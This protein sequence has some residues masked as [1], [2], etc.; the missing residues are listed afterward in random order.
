MREPDGVGSLHGGAAV[1]TI[2]PP[3]G[4]PLAGLFRERRATRIEQDL[5]VRALVLRNDTTTVALVVCD[6]IWLTG[7]TVAAAR[8]LIEHG[9][10]IRPAHVMISCTH[11]HTGPAT[12]DGL[13]IEADPTYL[14]WV[15]ARIAECVAAAVCRLVPVTVAS[16]AAEVAGVCFNRRFLM[17][18]GT[19]AF[20]P[21]PRNPNILHSVGPVDPVVTSVLVEDV[22]GNPVALSANLSLHYV[23]TDDECAI[24][25]DYYG[26]F[27]ANVRDWLGAGC[28]GLLTNGASGDINNVDVTATLSIRGTARARLVARAVAAAAIQATAMQRRERAPVLRGTS[29]RLTLHR[30]A[31]SPDDIALAEKILATPAAEAP[32]PA[33][34]SFVVGQPIPGYQIRQ[35]AIETL[36]V[37]AK[38]VSGTAELQIMQVGRAA[39]V[40]LPGE[41]FV[42]LGLDLKRRLPAP[43]T[44]V[45][46]LANDHIGYVPT[47]AAY[48]QGGYETWA[49]RSS[50]TAPGTGEAVVDAAVTLYEAMMAPG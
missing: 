9:T 20:N 23:G 12:S 14:D 44:A 22:A 50:W 17:A 43:V 35:Y 27:A 45:V 4:T 11:T 1:V 19:V 42:D 8:K 46:S 34:F 31:I 49:T 36:K 39:L 40:G 30:R 16:G 7:I 2:T 3:L 18:D 5:T 6:L 13:V 10:G 24:S 32:P 21:G 33:A 28:V 41:I 29:T 26:W 15:A 38:P 48:A 47:R 25:S 37:G